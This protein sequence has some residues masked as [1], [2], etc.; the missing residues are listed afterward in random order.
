MEKVA[1]NGKIYTILSLEE[2][3]FS[4]TVRGRLTKVLQAMDFE[5]RK[6]TAIN[7]AY[8]HGYAAVAVMDSP[9]EDV[10]EYMEEVGAKEIVNFEVPLAIREARED[11]MQQIEDI[12]TS[13]KARR[14]SVTP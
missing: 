1:I 4:D 10:I 5:D 6:M 11:E 13:I 8:S 14:R 12:I 9:I 3:N 2:L 7:V